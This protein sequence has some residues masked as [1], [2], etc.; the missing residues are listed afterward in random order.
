M[1]VALSAYA[2][3]DSGP[4]A[5]NF[6]SRWR[7]LFRYVRATD[8]GRSGVIRSIGN[9][10]LVYA[11]STGLWVKVKAGEFWIEGHWGQ[12]STDTIVPVTANATGAV[13]VD[14]VVCRA[15][16]PANQLEFECVAGSSPTTPPNRTNNANQYE[17]SLGSVAVP[18]GAGTIAAT[19]VFDGRDYVDHPELYG[20]CTADTTVNNTVTLVDVTGMSVTG[21]SN[22]A[23][24]WEAQIFYSAAAAADLRFRLVVPNGA[25]ALISNGSLAQSV[26]SGT[27]GSIDKGTTA[28]NSDVPLG[29]TG[30]GTKLAAKLEGWIVMPDV[31]G[32]ANTPMTIKT[33][34]AQVTADASNAVVYQ[35]SWMR[36]SRMA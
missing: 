9:E 12:T 10:G 13:R 15:N 23:Y 21:A 8:A 24:T 17:I 20:R 31:C 18:N 25:Q 2:P 4:G 34:M 36:L 30:T 27:S 33:Q 22:A 19:A 16:Y 11:D 6:E 26:V 29:A 3:F 32:T 1:A 35:N 5:A 14:R 7:D 28:G